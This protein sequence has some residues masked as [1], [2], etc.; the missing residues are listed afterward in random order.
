MAEQTMNNPLSGAEVV[1]AVLDRLRTELRKDCYL[2]PSSAYDWFSCK[3]SIELDMHDAGSLIKV[4]RAV[5]AENGDKPGEVESLQHVSG[6]F[7]IDPAPPNVV[8]VE[9]GQPVPTLTRDEHGKD[10]VKGVR[11]GRKDAAKVK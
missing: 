9:T 11:Y 1:E 7:H 6:G 3:V 8:R 4:D 2:N 10:V 5:T